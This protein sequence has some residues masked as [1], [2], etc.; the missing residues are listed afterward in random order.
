MR[1]YPE[2]VELTD[3]MLCL[4]G[5]YRSDCVV[6]T[7][8][9]G[10]MGDE[11]RCGQPIVAIVHSGNALGDVRMCQEHLD[12]TVQWMVPPGT[13]RDLYGTALLKRLSDKA[14]SNQ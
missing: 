12:S 13:P 6:V 8:T 5:E 2:G 10:Q 7:D 11:K 1:N 4:D 3:R 14:G 9:R